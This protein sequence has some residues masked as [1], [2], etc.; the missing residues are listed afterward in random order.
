MTR[1]A[2]PL[3][4]DEW[5]HSSWKGPDRLDQWA[6]AFL[7]QLQKEQ[8][9]V[10]DSFQ[11][12]KASKQAPTWPMPW[13]ERALAWLTQPT[14]TVVGPASDP[15]FPQRL[16]RLFFLSEQLAQSAMWGQ[17]G[18]YLPP[19][20]PFYPYRFEDRPWGPMTSP[21]PSNHEGFHRWQWLLA[22]G[23]SP[24]TPLVWGEDKTP[25]WE[26]V[27]RARMAQAPFRA[28]A[29]AHDSVRLEQMQR[30]MFFRRIRSSKNAESLS[31][32]FDPDE[33]H[34]DLVTLSDQGELALHA[35]LTHCPA[36]VTHRS[37]YVPNCVW[38]AKNPAGED[39]WFAVLRS[40]VRSGPGLLGVS[41]VKQLLA[42]V[43][44]SCNAQ[45]Q[46]WLVADP[47]LTDRVTRVREELKPASRTAC[48]SSLLKVVDRF[49]HVAWAGTAAEHARL[50]QRLW[51]APP[52]QEGKPSA[53]AALA[54]WAQAI[55]LEAPWV[56]P[57]LRGLSIGLMLAALDR[58]I[59]TT[60]TAKEWT[61]T[62]RAAMR[63]RLDEVLRGD[64]PWV[65]PT[66]PPSGT[67]W[68]GLGQ[69]LNGPSPGG[70]HL[71]A[72]LQRKQVLAHAEPAPS[73]PVGRPGLRRG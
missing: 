49:P 48:L 51:S 21:S 59:P 53:Y 30:A 8:K 16:V 1:S 58:P 37:L 13:A 42:Y 47:S 31:R 25:V 46:G 73:R 11:K 22:H 10:W 72:L 26:T 71:Q 50:A 36:L 67:P 39:A 29:A 28:W 7:G 62:D 4:L 2:A 69:H 18:P 19:S 20:A 57:E 40:P 35:A 60:A 24:E 33:S 38:E 63:Q 45:G 3:T 68:G 70:L 41:H 65:V 14:E 6:E 61:V 27:L 12:A 17:R 43:T 52:Q 23:I 66:T 44:P 15:K 54:R 9:D 34:Y 5:D 64:R 55:P 56:T 32:L